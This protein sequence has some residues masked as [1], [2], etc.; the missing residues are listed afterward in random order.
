M[1]HA[2]RYTLKLVL[3]IAS[4]TKEKL[5]RVNR[6]LEEKSDSNDGMIY[7]GQT[8]KGIEKIIDWYK[9]HPSDTLR[10]IDPYFHA[11]DLFIIKSLMDINNDLNCSILTNNDK[12]ES[13]NDIFQKGWNKLSDE[14]TGR[15]EI[16]SCC[17]EDDMKKCPWHDRWWLLYDDD[18]DQ[19]HGIRMAS[20]STLGIRISEISEM[21]E[22]A[23]NSANM[24]FNRFFINMAPK[25][26]GRKLVYQ[27]TKLR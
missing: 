15:I 25:N 19:Y 5:D 16:R 4:G 20:P 1:H 26:E 9:S 17:Y 14:I 18:N 10:I 12:A 3:A 13:I 7:V 2:I 24:I 21:G 27:E 23:I 6:I 8:T 22:D 11:D